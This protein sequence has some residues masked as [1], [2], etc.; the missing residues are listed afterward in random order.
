[1]SN[2]ILCIVGTIVG[3]LVLMIIMTDRGI[4]SPI[5]EGIDG[6]QY[7][8]KELFVLGFTLMRWFGIDVSSDM[9]QKK[10]K[11]LSELFGYKEAKKIVIYDIAAQSSYIAAFLPI[12]FLLTVV[13]DE[14]VIL[15]MGIGL[16]AI[17]VVYIEY[18]QVSKVNKR[19][20]VIQKEFPHIV[21]QM[22][23]LVNAGMPLR[24]VITISAQKG[25]GVLYLELQTLAE[26]MQNG[27]PDYEALDR[28]AARCGV[29]SVRKF[30]SLIIQNIKKGNSELAASLMDLSSEIWRNRVS[31]VK[32]QGEKA[33]TKLMV[34]IMIIFI[35]ILIM[36]IVP[37]FSGISL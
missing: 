15:L 19:H 23:L 31:M 30:S 21:S 27:I 13:M 37:I 25:E 34:P 32:E 20:E 29:D 2:I 9:I 1:M 26:D 16:V 22:A 12:A 14:P 5:I 8:M 28:F 36:V 11:K 10:I 17:L 3:L 4:Y 24:E 33:S 35:G 7:F 6:N 18:D